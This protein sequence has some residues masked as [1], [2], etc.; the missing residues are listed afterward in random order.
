MAYHDQHSGMITVSALDIQAVAPD[1]T[2]VG[3]ITDTL[4]FGGVEFVAHAGVITDGEFT[5]VLEES[6]DAT[7]TVSNVVDAVFI[8]NELT[9]VNF[10]NT[11]SN[12]TKRIGYVGKKRYVRWTTVNTG[13]A[14]GGTMSVVCLLT[15]ANKQPTQD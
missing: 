11:E 14:T 15:R 9:D 7:F 6:D 2:V 12:V 8:L 4:N 3:N 5:A 10:D 13:G 1:T